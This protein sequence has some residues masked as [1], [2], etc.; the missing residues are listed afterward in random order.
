MWPRHSTERM[1]PSREGAS[2]RSQER[3]APV[4][5]RTRSAFSR[6]TAGSHLSSTGVSDRLLAVAHR[7]AAR[8]RL[9]CFH[10]TVPTALLLDDATA[11]SPAR[12]AAFSTNGSSPA[13]RSSSSPRS[14]RPLGISLSVRSSG[15]SALSALSQALRRPATS[16]SALPRPSRLSL[17]ALASSVPESACG[18]MA[19]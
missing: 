9:G 7:Q 4:P 6:N 11:P 1:P 13:L 16:L 5:V 8:I 14:S 15:R 2:A 18:P 12:L 17:R 3:S 10:S 19:S